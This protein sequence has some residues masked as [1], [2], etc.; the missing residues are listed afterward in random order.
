MFLTHD[1]QQPV[2]R[3]RSRKALEELFD[4]I[5]GILKNFKIDTTQLMD[6]K[7][8]LIED[9]MNDSKMFDNDST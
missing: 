5:A 7:D 8:K 1:R 4:A 9:I 3:N 6:N 2:E